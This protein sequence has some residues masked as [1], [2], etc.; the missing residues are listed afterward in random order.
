MTRLAVVGTGRW[1]R[2]HVRTFANIPGASIVAVCDA[3]PEALRLGHALAPDAACL[4]RYTD[5]LADRSIEAVVLATPA[6]EHAAMALA[7]LE[8][9]KHVLVEKPLALCVEDAV[10]VADAAERV[11]RVLMVGHIMLFHPSVRLI[12]SMVREGVLGQISHVYASRLN[13]PGPSEGCAMWSLAP[14]DISLAMYLMEST[15]LSVRARRGAPSD[16]RSS[17]VAF[18]DLEF[19]SGFSRMHL[20]RV[21]P[22]KERRTTVVGSQ[23][24]VDFDDTM[25]LEKVRF[26]K[27]PGGHG[28]PPSALPSSARNEQLPEPLELECRHF[29]ECVRERRSPDADSRSG[30]EV[31]RILEA[32]QRSADANGT[33]IHLSD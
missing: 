18:V 5:V 26:R 15:P 12:K 32:A 25:T 23:T 13:P 33:K 19:A 3:S 4:P 31:I 6:V 11:D 2:N 30:V 7:A 24:T 1:G 21:H 9:G 29:L 20:S 28:S 22:W 27:S 16:A 10:A 14:H 8:A 17:D